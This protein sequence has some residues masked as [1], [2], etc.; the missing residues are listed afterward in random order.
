MTSNTVALTADQELAKVQNKLNDAMVDFDRWISQNPVS[1][2]KDDIEYRLK[3]QNIKLLKLK[4]KEISELKEDYQ[5]TLMIL[6]STP[7]VYIDPN[8]P[9]AFTRSKNETIPVAPGSMKIANKRMNRVSTRNG[10]V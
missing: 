2:N 4:I 3:Q 10:V 1:A 8:T 7:T 5:N 6:S 9:T